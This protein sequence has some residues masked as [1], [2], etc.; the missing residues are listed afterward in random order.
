MSPHQGS[1]ENLE[2]GEKNERVGE[3][4]G[5]LWNTDFGYIIAIAL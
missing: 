1:G 3:R 4:G 5:V 2:C